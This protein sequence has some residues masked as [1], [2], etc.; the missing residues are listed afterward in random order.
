MFISIFKIRHLGVMKKIPYCLFSIFLGIC[1]VS[2]SWL[3]HRFT[4]VAIVIY[5]ATGIIYIMGVLRHQTSFFHKYIGHSWSILSVVFAHMFWVDPFSDW[6]HT[7]LFIAGL[8]AALCVIYLWIKDTQ[9]KTEK[10]TFFTGCAAVLIALGIAF[11]PMGI[12]ESVISA[13]EFQTVEI[14]E[15][16]VFVT[17]TD[18]FVSDA[19]LITLKQPNGKL[20]GYSGGISQEY[21]NSLQVGDDVHICVYTGSLGKKFYSFFEDPD[22][23]FYG[24]NEWTRE[25]Y[26]EYLEETQ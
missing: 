6:K 14:A 16:E 23:D 26:A 20:D 9:T 18:L 8:S 1:V 13:Y 3:P 25:K 17:D 12:N 11:C 10:F 21:W 4:I 15:K 5:I 7:S 19:Y 24:Y 2:R 22:S